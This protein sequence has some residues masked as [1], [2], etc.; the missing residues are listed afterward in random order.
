MVGQDC[1]FWPI[2]SIN[3]WASN[4]LGDKS[5]G[6]TCTFVAGISEIVCGYNWLFTLHCHDAVVCC[7]ADLFHHPNHNAEPILPRRL[8]SES[9]INAYNYYQNIHYWKKKDYY[10]SP[11]SIAFSRC[12]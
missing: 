1:I 12:A 9:M 8:L 4:A 11:H 3:H 2:V 10:S 6:L 5:F 7:G